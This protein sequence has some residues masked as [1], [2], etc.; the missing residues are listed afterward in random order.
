MALI[1]VDRT[2]ETR[3]AGCAQTRVRIDFVSAAGAVV[4]RCSLTL[5]DVGLAVG[6]PEPVLTFTL[7]KISAINTLFSSVSTWKT[8]TLVNF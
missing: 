4:T 3:V 6:S 7:I 2:A 8:R 1:D 5:V